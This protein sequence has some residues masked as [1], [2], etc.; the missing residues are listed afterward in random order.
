[1]G[2]DYAPRETLKGALL[3]LKEI[4]DN[5]QL[6]LIGDK[7]IIR[8]FLR[9]NN[10]PE[11]DFEIIH[12]SQVIE[13]GE[14]PTRAFSQKSDS[15]IAVG[16][17][18]LKEG[19]LQG[20]ASAGNTGAMMVGAMFSLKPIA[21]IIRPAISSIIPKENGGVGVILDVGMNADCKPEM[22][23]QFALLGSLLAEYVYH[24]PL[25]KVG[26]MNIGEEAEKGNILMQGTHQLLRNSKEINFIGN[27]EG[28][29]LF[30]E[31]ADVVVCDGFTGNVIL[32]EAE[33]LFTIMRKRGIRDA[34]FDRFNYENY[35]GT[36][37]LGINSSVVIA[38]G[39]SNAVAIKNMIMLTNTVAEVKLAE[40]ISNAMQMSAVNI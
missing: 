1:M 17:R 33:S 21:G 18:L 7:N 5:I 23:Q 22:L 12:T 40:K 9:E 2:G 20:F 29:D 10:V 37:L 30:N 25:P 15:S 4:S 6:V 28:R 38:H 31:K 27:I 36:P 13:M 3:A 35:G 16:F 24:I 32:K 11:S 8:P 19:S 26:L 34:Y 39:I 14:V